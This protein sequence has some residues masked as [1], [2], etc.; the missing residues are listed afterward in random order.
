M[1]VISGFTHD[2]RVYEIG[3]IIK[4]SE[5][6]EAG[7]LED[8]IGILQVRF[9]RQVDMLP[10]KKEE[11]FDARALKELTYFCAH[12]H[13]DDG[14]KWSEVASGQRRPSYNEYAVGYYNLQTQILDVIVFHPFSTIAL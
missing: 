4:A 3:S 9:L 1:T 7:K 10:E 14:Q 12:K 8:M 2:L 5:L 13:E 11:H 6:K